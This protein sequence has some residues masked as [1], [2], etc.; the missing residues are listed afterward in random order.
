MMGAK[1]CEPYKHKFP[2]SNA[3]SHDRLFIPMTSNYKMHMT[4]NLVVPFR[5]YSTSDTN[6]VKFEMGI[7]QGIGNA[8]ARSKPNEWCAK[9]EWAGPSKPL[10]EATTQKVKVQHDK[11]SSLSTTLA[12]HRRNRTRANYQPAS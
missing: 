1:M 2:D 11:Y 6:S 10:M 5:R 8:C 12:C 4:Y 9:Y 3:S 7:V